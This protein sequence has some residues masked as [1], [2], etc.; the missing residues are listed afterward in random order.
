M[1]VGSLAFADSKPPLEVKGKVWANFAYDLTEDSIHKNGFDIYRAYLQAN[2]AFDEQWS[3]A[4]LLD[5][6]RGESVATADGGTTKANLWMYLRNAYIQ[7]SGLWPEGG[8]I[9]FGLQPTPFISFVDNATKTR[10]LGKSML[11]QTGI[12]NSQSSGVSALGSFAGVLKYH[13]I[14]HNGT[15]GLTKPGNSDNGLALGVQV[16]V[17]PFEGT[18]SWFEKMTLV[19]Y[20]ENQDSASSSKAM[21][22]TKGTSSLAHIEP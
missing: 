8:T 17:Q 5:A 12:L 13:V 1:V 15:E 2:Y 10:W 14:L 9:R 6:Q 4:L 3:A 21:K 11:D 22:V 19:G 20:S 18:G 16:A 7:G